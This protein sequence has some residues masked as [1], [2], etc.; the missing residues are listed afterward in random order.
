MTERMNG[1]AASR[2]RWLRAAA[3]LAGMWLA[4]AQ[5]QAPK[6]LRVGFIAQYEPFSFVDT[7]GKLTGFDVEVVRA[8]LQS[9]GMAMAIESGSAEKLRTMAKAG[10]IDLIGN[11]LLMVPQNRALFDFVRP[12]ATVQLACVQ[13][14]DDDRDFL[15]L[16]DFVGKRLGVL[17]DTGIE[18]QARGALGGSVIG[19]A[20]IEQ[21]LVAL[22]SKKSTPCWRKA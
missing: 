7:T 14:E 9:L 10:Q 2:R 13:H 11:Q 3:S 17:R 6:V 19:Y 20:Q 12:Y 8:L 1:T 22:S 5:A 21:A 16:D 15:S 4:V 18:D